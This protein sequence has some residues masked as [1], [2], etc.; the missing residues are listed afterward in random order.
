MANTSSQHESSVASMMPI[1]DEAMRGLVGCYL[2]DF[3]PSLAG[4]SSSKL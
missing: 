3:I 1:S 4:A 2:V